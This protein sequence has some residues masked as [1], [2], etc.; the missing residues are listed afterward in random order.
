MRTIGELTFV[1]LKALPTKL[2]QEAKQH[3]LLS[4]FSLKTASHTK[5]EEDPKLLHHLTQSFTKSLQI[6]T[7]TCKQLGDHLG[8]GEEL[9]SHGFLGALRTENSEFII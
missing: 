1:H 5:E 9:H 4:L 3:S 7:T 6:H 8:L 2:P